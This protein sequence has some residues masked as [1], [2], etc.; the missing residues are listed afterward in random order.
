MKQKTNPTPKGRKPVTALV[1][2]TGGPG[3]QCD[4]LDRFITESAK[5]V[6][7]YSKDESLPSGEHP[8][9]ATFADAFKKMRTA[10]AQAVLDVLRK[11]TE[12]ELT[13]PQ[14]KTAR[15]CVPTGCGKIT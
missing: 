3:Y 10:A 5:A 14:P 13:G 2:T 1:S 8:D 9:R 6:A 12:V 7:G 15:L 4:S 11:E